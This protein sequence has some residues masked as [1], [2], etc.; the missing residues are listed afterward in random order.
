MREKDERGGVQKDEKHI[1]SS[2]GEGGVGAGSRRAHLSLLPSSI[3]LFCHTTEG[4]R[5]RWRDG[6]GGWALER[7]FLP[8][9]VHLLLSP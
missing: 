7:F 8:S 9:C 5:E 1:A 3:H 6:G 4:G 2:V